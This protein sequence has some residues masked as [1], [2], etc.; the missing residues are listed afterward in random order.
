[1][2]V[3]PRTMDRI[4]VLTVFGTRPEAIKL[5]PVIEELNRSKDSI[6]STICVTGQHRQMLDQVLDLFGICPDYDLNIMKPKQSL[7]GVTTAVLEGLVA[8]LDAERPDWVIV[9]GDTTTAMSATLAAF[10]AGIKVGH[11]EAGLR[12]FDNSQPFPEEANR[13]LVS[14]LADLHFAPTDW[15]ARNLRREGAVEQRII[16]TGNTVIDALRR[17]SLLPFDPA[18]SPLA[19]LPHDGT[20]LILVTAHRRE[21]L[22]PRLE[23][24]CL[25]LKSIVESRTDVHLVFPVHLNPRVQDIVYRTLGNLP[26]VTLLPPLDYHP[27]IWILG[28]CYLVVTDSG[29][30]QEEAPGLGKPVLVLRD[31]TERPEGLEAGTVRLVGASRASVA[32][33]IS[34]LL[35]DRAAYESMAHATNPYGDGHAAR[36]IVDGLISWSSS[37]SKE[38]ATLVRVAELDGQMAS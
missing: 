2:I 11:V 32:D 9:Q 4:K 17:T 18:G 16:V 31:T 10:Y 26:R 24:I 28:R 19:A 1:V 15:A 38:S 34:Q 14:V 6:Y 22:G 20:R 8:V 7:T 25:G 30:L 13:R 23:E 27:L 3:A 36:R 37:P 33:S 21:N 35:D 12:T 5:A 29:G